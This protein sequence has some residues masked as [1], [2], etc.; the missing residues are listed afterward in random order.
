MHHHM[1]FK[2]SIRLFIYSG[3]GT[4]IALLVIILAVLIIMAST[5]AFGAFRKYKQAHVPKKGECR[6]CLGQF[7]IQLYTYNSTH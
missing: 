6:N 7:N 2:G 3:N 4:F 5:M 1:Y